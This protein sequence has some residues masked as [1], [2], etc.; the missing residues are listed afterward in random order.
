MI[1]VDT[2]IW[3][4]HL[5]RTDPD[6]S[7]LLS[8]GAVLS[9]PF[10]IGELACGGLSNRAEILA[11]LSSLLTAELA[12]HEQVLELV[13]VHALHGRGLGWVDVHL[14]AAALL[15]PCELWTRDKSLDAAARS[16]KVGR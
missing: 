7:S 12:S 5:R 11:L 2:S 3:V 6:L 10:V 14:L 1:L 13:R 16:L 9:H 4:D 8:D 15:T